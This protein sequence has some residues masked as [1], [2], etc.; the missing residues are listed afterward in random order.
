VCGRPCRI[1]SSGISIVGHPRTLENHH[2][3][4]DDVSNLG[5]PTPPSP[6]L[7]VF[8]GEAENRTKVDG[9]SDSISISPVMAFYDPD[10]RHREESLGDLGGFEEGGYRRVEEGWVEVSK[11]AILRPRRACEE[12]ARRIGKLTDIRGT[13]IPEVLVRLGKAARDGGRKETPWSVYFSKAV[14]DS[15]RVVD[16]P[17]VVQFRLN[18]TSTSRP[19]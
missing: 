19:A 11:G 6:V 8:G 18:T 3:L 15:H 4:R 1:G 5:C 14:K 2:L 7:A 10:R 16:S 13:D 17:A 12:L 9:D